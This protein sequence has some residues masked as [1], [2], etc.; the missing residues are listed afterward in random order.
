MLIM[1]G[2]TGGHVYPALA[3]AEVLRSRGVDVVWV[4]T[5]KGF[6]SKV[7]PA[8]G[9]E[10]D[11]IEVSGLRGKGWMRKLAMPVILLRACFQTARVILRRKPNALLGMGGFVAGPGGFM[12]WLLRCPLVIHEANAIAGLTNRVLSPLARRV[13]TGFPDVAQLGERARWVGNPVRREIA[14]LPPP[15]ERYASR[16]DGLRLLI[17]GGSQGARIFNQ[18][19]PA[20]I[21]DRRSTTPLQIR[22]QCGRGNKQNVADAYGAVSV[23]ATVE[24]FIDDMAAAY[25]WADLVICRS[26]AMTVAEICAAGVAAVLVPFPF[27][28]GDHQSANASFLS[29]RNAAFLVSQDALS[30][31]TLDTIF[32]LDRT[33]LCEVASNARQL[34]RPDATNTVADECTGVM[35]A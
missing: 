6:E 22:H 35:G 11:W 34:S 32:E 17:F 14:E 15:D 26:G 30:R 8:A 2:G 23:P 20:L 4:G 21:A 29:E 9:F 19:L 12:G 1:A 7:V 18:E 24:E 28:V 25:R 3:V 27:A 31:A 33:L 16:D 13:L 5:R 10:I